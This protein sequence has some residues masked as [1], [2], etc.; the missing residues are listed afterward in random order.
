MTDAK[1][2]IS[3][4]WDK[5]SVTYD[6][7]YGH[8]LKSDAEANVWKARLKEIAGDKPLKILD[9]CT[10]TGFLALFFAELG[11]D[12]KGVDLSEGMMGKAREKA[13]AKG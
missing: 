11:H 7:H 4:C 3:A 9:V 10:G 13:A 8:G 5:S 12:V 2:E 6:T 1:T